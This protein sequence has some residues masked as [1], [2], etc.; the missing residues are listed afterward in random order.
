MKQLVKYG[1][2]TT[3]KTADKELLECLF[4]KDMLKDIGELV[5]EKRNYMGLSQLDVGDKTGIDH[6]F[7]QRFEKGKENINL[8]TLTVLCQTL[9][10]PITIGN[11]S[12]KEY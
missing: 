5:K 8:R 1:K 3:Y 7:I 11:I 2:H 12:I 9:S 10:I 4:N 6:K